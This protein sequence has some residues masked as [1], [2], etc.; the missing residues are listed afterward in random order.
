[1]ERKAVTVGIIGTGFMGKAHA[2][3][4]QLFDITVGMFASRTLKNAGSA[5]EQF[6][7]ERWTDNWLELV[8][9]PQIDCVDITVP[10]HLHYEIAM[11][12]IKAGKPFLIEKPLARNTEEGEEIVR[13]A[14]EKGIVAVYA[15]NMRFKPALVRTKQLVDE[16]AF[17]NILMLRSNEI[18]NG[19]FHAP[20]FWDAKLTGG[21]AAID[22]GIHGVNTLEWIMGSK[23]KRVYAETGVLKWS[24][25]CKNGA[26]D[27]A[28]AVLRFENGGMA[29]LA[30]SW[31][32]SGGMDVRLEVFGT[33][34]TAYVSTTHEAGGLKI[35]SNKGYG[36]PLEVE[37]SQK[38]HVVDTKGW[39]FPAPKDVMQQG[40]AFE[41]KHFIDCVRGLA[42]PSSTLEDGL[43]SLAVIEAMY[44]S[45]AKGIAVEL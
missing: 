18:H 38:P 28:M 14:K 35:Y 31:A 41:V 34:G 16:G 24:E 45:A 44:E 30:I 17:G 22:M 33:E 23:I 36:R 5:A 43:R 7:V 1:M 26:E 27:T 29:E 2:E 11:A 10:N 32:I 40:H 3:G 13:A 6:G 15:E 12:C 37:A 39:S 19:P 4:Y 42:Q 8:Q 9:D 20:W 25:Q 21:G